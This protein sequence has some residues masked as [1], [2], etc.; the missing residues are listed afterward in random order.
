M[1]AVRRILVAVKDMRLG[2]RPVVR[3]AA[4]IASA[5]NAHLEIYHCLSEPLTLDIAFDAAQGLAG[6]ERDLRQQ[7]LHRLER[8]AESIRQRQ[9]GLKVTVAAEWDAPAYDAIVRRAHKIKADLVVAAGH[10][11]AHV[12]PSLM[13]LT[14]WELIRLSPVPLLLVKNPRPYR[15]PAILV[16]VDPSH[17]F[18]KPMQLD[19]V[20]LRTGD[21]LSRCLRGTLH[22]V[23]AYARVP[24]GAIS[25]NELAGADYG[26]RQVE[27]AAKRAAEVRLQRALKGSS[28]TTSRRYLVGRHPVDAILQAA[29]KSHS[30]IVVMG[31]ISRSGLKRLLIGNTAESILDE[32]R[33]DVLVV[34]PSHFKNR[35][36]RAVQGPQIVIPP[37]GPWGGS[38]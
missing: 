30:A 36:P 10:S 14:D 7:A 24:S 26:L 16:A 9:P 35:V 25:P 28:I 13:R 17:T 27:K 1:P 3:K 33:C 2:V 15:R 8:I 18:S 12:L 4:Q 5:C 21:A 32:L 20:L 6:L 19:K 29:R 23:H 37:A 31:A 11:G 38:Y 34:K 22:A